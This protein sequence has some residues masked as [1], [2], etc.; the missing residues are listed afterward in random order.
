MRIDSGKSWLSFDKPPLIYHTNT[1]SSTSTGPWLAHNLL[2]LFSLQQDFTVCSEI[3]FLLFLFIA[4]RSHLK[5]SSKSQHFQMDMVNLHRYSLPQCEEVYK[6]QQL[7]L[8]AEYTFPSSILINAN[9]ITLMIPI[10][11]PVNQHFQTI[12]PLWTL[13]KHSQKDLFKI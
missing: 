9:T 3:G 8:D 4:D 1:T 6:S 13:Y 12:N 5:C 10:Y 7:T 2:L 11:H